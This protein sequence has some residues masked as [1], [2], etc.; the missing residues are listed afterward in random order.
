[1]TLPLLFILFVW[2]GDEVIAE[3]RNVKECFIMCRV[4][5]KSEAKRRNNEGDIVCALLF[6]W[7]RHK[8][9]IYAG[10]RSLRGDGVIKWPPSPCLSL[11]PA[12]RQS[13]TPKNRKRCF[14][15]S[16]PCSRS[17]SSFSDRI[18][19][20]LLSNM[21]AAW[22]EVPGNR[23][24]NP[25]YHRTLSSQSPLPTRPWRPFLMTMAFSTSFPKHMCVLYSCINHYKVTNAK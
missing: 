6:G 16:S 3:N 2:V 25:A 19:H 5:K 17:C 13:E 18:G 7:V 24:A 10:G 9:H 11:W 21:S 15:S 20:F 4:V 22:I 1:M 23:A 12:G 8:E 14:C